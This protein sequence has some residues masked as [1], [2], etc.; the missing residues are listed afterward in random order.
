MFSFFAT[1][2]VLRGRAAA[3]C[4]QRPA[5]KF[6]ASFWCELSGPRRAFFELAFFLFLTLA[7]AR[8]EREFP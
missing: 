8:G 6:S 7:L 1:E 5:R 2:K 4:D 3:T